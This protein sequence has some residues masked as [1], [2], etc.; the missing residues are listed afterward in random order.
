M[1]RM[2]RATDVDTWLSYDT[3]HLERAWEVL[4][5]W[6]ENRYQ[7]T[8]GIEGI[9]FLIGLRESGTGYSPGMKKTEKQDTIMRGTAHAFESLG[10]YSKIDPDSVDAGWRAAMPV[11]KLP[12]NQQEKL[13]RLAIVSYFAD[14]VESLPFDSDPPQ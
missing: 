5:T 13:V 6:L 14:V 12:V 7:K 10:L 9:L 2:R 8:F 1:P 11:P 4:T 3:D